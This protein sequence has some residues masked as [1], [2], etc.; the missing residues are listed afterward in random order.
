MS[1]KKIGPL[2]ATFLVAGNMIGAGVYLLPASLGAVGSVSILGWIVTSV[3]ALLLA[4]VFSALFRLR[5]E[6]HG[7]IAQVRDG[8]GGFFGFQS[9]LLYWIG[10][11]VGNVAIAVAASGYLASF[12]PAL[13]A[14]PAAA[15]ST[16]GLIWLV[17]ALNF[18]GARRVTDFK[19]LALVI[20]LAPVLGVAVFGWIAFDADVFIASWNVSGRTDMAAVPATFALIFWAFLGLESAAVAAAVVRNPGRDVPIATISGAA[21]AACVYIAASGAMMG[22]LPAAQLAASTAPFADAAARWVG[23]IA[24]ALV[25]VCAILKAV[26]TLSGWALVTAEASRSGAAAGVFPALFHEAGGGPPRRNLIIVAALMSLVALLTASPRLAAQF[27]YL[28]NLSVLPFLI[29]F[30]YCC[31]SL[32][33]LCAASPAR[34]PLRFV[35]VMAGVF[36]EWAITATDIVQVALVAAVAVL[37][38]PMYLLMRPSMAANAAER[39]T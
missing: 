35:A 31:V 4:L 15:A 10:C 32:W 8:M 7:V 24:G 5:P 2:R 39:A 14:A 29:V 28:V 1:D 17:A 12:F 34:W 22:L 23:P 38:L 20:G 37:A 19:A 25:A 36:C 21:L 11:W 9:S 6:A 18:F 16:I 3:G 33:R 26:G 27:T 13:R 30:T